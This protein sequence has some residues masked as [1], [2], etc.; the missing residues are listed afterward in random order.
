MQSERQRCAC[1]EP[2]STIFQNYY[3]LMT[4][5]AIETYEEFIFQ[6]IRPY[7]ELVMQRKISKKVLEQ[8]LT[9]YFENHPQNQD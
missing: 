7:C 2:Y 5:Q 3:D 9:E 6:T 4:I 1:E 8:A